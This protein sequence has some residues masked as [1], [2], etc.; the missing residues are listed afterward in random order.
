MLV[1]VCVFG[2]NLNVHARPEN[3]R[4][5]GDKLGFY[6]HILKVISSIHTAAEMHEETELASDVKQDGQRDS[7]NLVSTGLQ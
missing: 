7:H 2:S 4:L 3:L 1:S 6:I 5:L